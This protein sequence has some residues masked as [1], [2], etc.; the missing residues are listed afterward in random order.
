[1]KVKR[2]SHP[3]RITQKVTN[4]KERMSSSEVLN[5]DNA[6]NHNV[7]SSDS[8]NGPKLEDQGDLSPYDNDKVTLNI[9]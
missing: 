7:F 6:T 1:M 8:E 5:I 4:L 9:S 3:D 2:H